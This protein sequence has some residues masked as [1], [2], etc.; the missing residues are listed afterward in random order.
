VIL[1]I[2]P[3]L[4]GGLAWMSGASEVVTFAI[5][6]VK[7][8]TRGRE[9]QWNV[10]ADALDFR[11]VE[12]AFVEQV[13]ARPGQGTASMFKFGFVCGG[14]RGILAAKRIPVTYVSPQAWK[15]ALH[16]GAG[17]DAARARAAELF[18][19]AASQFARVK[20]DGVAEAALI[21]CYGWLQI[22][23]G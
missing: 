20:D 1:G 15:K 5:P 3:G 14:I 7:A 23:R 17:K 10:L 22:K 12:H 13:G 19:Q 9:I 4:S 6:S 16:L 11:E 2:D 8:R 21:A 18:P